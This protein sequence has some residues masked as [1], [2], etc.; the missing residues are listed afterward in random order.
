MARAGP[1]PL[2]STGR[3]QLA[4]DPATG[5]GREGRLA[6]QP[7]HNSFYVYSPAGRLSGSSYVLFLTSLRALKHQTQF[8]HKGQD[9]FVSQDTRPSNPKHTE[10][11]PEKHH[12]YLSI[13]FWYEWH[14]N[15]KKGC[16]FLFFMMQQFTHNVHNE[17]MYNHGRETLLAD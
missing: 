2:W 14:H 6:Y 15:M 12:T 8:H 1:R 10:Q 4:T 3:S 13:S 7:V 11:A 16:N 9:S 5:G 17:M